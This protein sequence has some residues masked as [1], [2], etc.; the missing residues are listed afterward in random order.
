VGKRTKVTYTVNY[1]TADNHPISSHD[2]SCLETQLSAC[3]AQ[4][5]K[6]ARIAA[7]KVK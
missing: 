4:I 6:G 1:S 5:V 3:A 7:R 2:G